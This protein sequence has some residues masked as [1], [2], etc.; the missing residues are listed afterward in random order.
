MISSRNTLNQQAQAIGGRA[1]RY[2][3]PVSSFQ[4]QPKMLPVAQPAQQTKQP[5]EAPSTLD[6]IASG[7]AGGD[8]GVVENLPQSY[9]P[10]S[11]MRSLLD[12]YSSGNVV[13]IAKDRLVSGLVG[14]VMASL[15]GATV[16]QMMEFGISS[17]VPGPM[18]VANIATQG[19]MDAVAK[20]KLEDTY[21][22]YLGDVDK[23]KLESFARVGNETY[24]DDIGVDPD[25]SDPTEEFN[26]EDVS[27][28]EATNTMLDQYD[29]MTRSPV[30]QLA[31]FIGDT[32]GIGP[33]KLTVF[34]TPEIPPE[35]LKR[36][37]A[38]RADGLRGVEDRG[39]EQDFIS[40]LNE[41]AVR[42]YGDYGID[43]GKELP[44][45][46]VDPV[47]FAPLGKA[48]PSED[49]L[50]QLES[51][52]GSLFGGGG[53]DGGAADGMG[54]GGGG[55]MSHGGPGAG[56]GGSTGD[57]GDMGSDEGNTGGLGW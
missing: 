44:Y 31:G 20:S 24:A 43:V 14:G 18:G 47:T 1:S 28:Y 49:Y 38:S 30:S 53:G 22:E 48:I 4:T 41:D 45:T 52:F 51:T 19:A 40:R 39:L 36:L 27:L 32:M 13:D 33:Q 12:D 23:P 29:Q 9:A 42:E 6:A 10:A 21:S 11:D 5:V 8:A 34:G 25:V 50:A 46:P 57:F 55:G 54:G 26:P 56:F 17:M 15:A 3:T 16:P 7:V 37:Q 2:A 35:L